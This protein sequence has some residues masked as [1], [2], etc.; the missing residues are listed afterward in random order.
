MCSL[1]TIVTWFLKTTY[2]LIWIIDTFEYIIQMQSNTHPVVSA[3]LS[4]PCAHQYGKY[5]HN[6]GKTTSIMC[7]ASVYVLS[8]SIN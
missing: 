8:D 1:V 7:G 6:N 2:D 3:T 5:E 4:G